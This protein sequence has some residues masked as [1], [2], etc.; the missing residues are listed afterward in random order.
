M[1]ACSPYWRSNFRDVP[2]AAF[3]VVEVHAQEHLGPVLCLGA[4]GA[5]LDGE[6]AVERVIFA[7][8]QGLELDLFGAGFEGGKVAV[9]SSSESWSLPRGRARRARAR[10]PGPSAATRIGSS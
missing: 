3:E 9:A 5:G 4:A 8:E 10:R 7:V 6:E 2:A 1:P